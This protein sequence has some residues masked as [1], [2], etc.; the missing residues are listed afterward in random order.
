V[1]KLGQKISRG[2]EPAQS[3]RAETCWKP[4]LVVKHKNYGREGEEE[5]GKNRGKKASETESINSTLLSKK[6]IQSSRASRVGATRKGVDLTQSETNHKK[7]TE[8]GGRGKERQAEKR[9]EKKAEEIPQ[10]LETD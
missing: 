6:R 1:K 10:S 3:V 8:A 4:E 7:D 5:R 9:E 2:G